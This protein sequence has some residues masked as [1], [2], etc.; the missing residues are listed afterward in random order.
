MP[1]GDIPPR[2]LLVEDDADIRDLLAGF[3][4]DEGFTVATAPNGK[5]ALAWLG[6]HPAPRVIL[7]DLWMPVMTGEEF[8]E[9]QMRDPVLAAI[10]VVIITAATDGPQRATALGVE[11]WIRKPV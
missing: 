10:P 4:E 2:V 11:G 6:T 3:L 8:R 5:E 1:T 7:L 9:V